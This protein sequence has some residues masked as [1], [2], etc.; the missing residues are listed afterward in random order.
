MLSEL[1]TFIDST[2]GKAFANQDPMRQEHEASM[3][4]T[5]SL[6]GICNA[7]SNIDVAYQPGAY[8][9]SFLAAGFGDNKSGLMSRI[10]A[11]NPNRL[12]GI[13]EKKP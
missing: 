9:N 2:K 10:R 8:D 6:S 4:T 13:H 7:N 12:R 5:T 11:R 1:P 3:N